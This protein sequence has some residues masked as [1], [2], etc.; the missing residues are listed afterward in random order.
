MNDN[1]EK[2]SYDNVIEN[3]DAVLDKFVLQP[4][5]KYYNNHELHKLS[6]HVHQTNDF[7]LLLTNI[8]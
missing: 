2:R 7:S 8:C 1:D 4:I 6:T 5:F 3:N